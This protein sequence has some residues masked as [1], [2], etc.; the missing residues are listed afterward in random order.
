MCSRA[1]SGFLSGVEWLRW[2]GRRTAAG[3]VR[4]RPGCGPASAEAISDQPG[5]SGGVLTEHVRPVLSRWLGR[6]WGSVGPLIGSGRRARGIDRG[7]DV[8]VEHPAALVV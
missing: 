5:T 3:E 4:D 7:V 2:D 6:P 8:E 1:S